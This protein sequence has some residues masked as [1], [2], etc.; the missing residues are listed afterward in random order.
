MVSITTRV[1]G[2][3][4]VM[5]R[6]A[7]T[8]PMP[9]MFRSMTTTSG[10][11]S[12]TIRTAS[13]PPAASPTTWTPCSSSRL[14]RPVRNR[15]WS[16]T[17]ST[18]SDSVWRSSA[19]GSTSVRTNPP[20]LSVASLNATWPDGWCH[21]FAN[22]GAWPGRAGGRRRAGGD[23]S[24]IGAGA[25]ARS[26]RCG[27]GGYAAADRPAAAPPRQD[28]HPDARRRGT[29]HLVQGD[30]HRAA[31]PGPGLAEGREPEIDVVAPD[32]AARIGGDALAVAGDAQPRPERDHGRVDGHDAPA[33]GEPGRRVAGEGVAGRAD[34]D[35]SS[36]TRC[37]DRGRGRRLGCGG[38]SGQRLLRGGRCLEGRGLLLCLLDAA[39]E[40]RDLPFLQLLLAPQPRD[41]RNALR[42]CRCEVGERLPCGRDRCIEACAARFE[43]ALLPR[44]PILR[45]FGCVDDLS[46]LI[47]NRVERVELRYRGVEC[48]RAEHDRERADVVLLVQPAQIERELVARRRQRLLRDADLQLQTLLFCAQNRGLRLHRRQTLLRRLHARFECI[49]AERCRPPLRFD[50]TELV[51][52]PARTGCS[53]TGDSGEDD[54]RSGRG[55]RRSFHARRAHRGGTVAR[56]G[57]NPATLCEKPQSR[58]AQNLRQ[59]TG[60]LRELTGCRCPEPL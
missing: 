59:N 41:E 4:P 23:G 49:E 20:S 29:N 52:E 34:D 13:A 44:E 53:R 60:T 7:S 11:S 55:E 56:N 21:G 32:G 17:I 38:G 48:L 40:G 39:L 14:R 57:R 19:A 58:F 54:H 33:D 50:R 28:A 16:S 9:G 24:A 1:S 8:P 6:V 47:R 27:S 2:A 15:S 35:R 5:W 12:R 51:L 36:A 45:A 42:L 30:R 18:R 37:R 26:R 43:R 10:A 31:A 46:A 3:I 22:S 25:T